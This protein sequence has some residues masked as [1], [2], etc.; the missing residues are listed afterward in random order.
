MPPTPPCPSRSTKS[1][2]QAAVYGRAFCSAEA[3]PRTTIREAAQRLRLLNAMRDPQV[4]RPLTHQQLE[5]QTLLGL[6]SHLTS[7]FHHLLALHISSAMALRT[8]PV[9]PPMRVHGEPWH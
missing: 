9:R 6:V 2:T 5:Q 7:S 1:P 4:G 8:E 3:L